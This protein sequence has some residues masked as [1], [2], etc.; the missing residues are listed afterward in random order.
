MKIDP[1]LASYVVPIESVIRFPDNPRKGDLDALVD[2]LRRFGQ[3][4]PIL[5]QDATSYVVAG[6]HLRDAALLMSS[7]I[8]AVKRLDLSDVEAAAYVLA[9]NR[10]ADLAWYDNEALLGAI[11]EVAGGTLLGTGFARE[12]L[13]ELISGIA[14][15]GLP[16]SGPA[17]SAPEGWT[18]TALRE[19]V[20]HFDPDRAEEFGQYVA[21][22][23][24]HFRIPSAT[25][26]IVDSVTRASEALS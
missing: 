19:I 12:D 1:A 26:A 13:A 23:R 14:A 10:L 2:S 17:G 4:R 25:K 6:N 21:K 15:A 8:I 16:P 3:V 9:D 18:P 5:V 22:V 20:L 7:P 24:E 11:R